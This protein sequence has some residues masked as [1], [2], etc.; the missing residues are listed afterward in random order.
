MDTFAFFS[1]IN[2]EDFEIKPKITVENQLFHT[3]HRAHRIPEAF[4]M[5]Y[6]ET[7]FHVTVLLKG[8]GE[9]HSL[10]KCECSF[11]LFTAHCKLLQKL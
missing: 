9:P 5:I 6:V 3:F 7:A 11:C 2:C 1:A 8:H 4:Y 10:L